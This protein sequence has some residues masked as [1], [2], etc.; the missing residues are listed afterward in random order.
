MS[1]T[2]NIRGRS[3]FQRPHGN[4]RN[5]SCS[6]EK[7]CLNSIGNPSW[8]IRMKRAIHKVRQVFLYFDPIPQGAIHKLRR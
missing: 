6:T 3:V 4:V 7:K 1:R 8:L 5:K 2:I